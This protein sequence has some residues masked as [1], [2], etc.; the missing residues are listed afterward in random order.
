MTMKT[1][2]E[3]IGE[4]SALEQL[5]EECAE[6]AQASL[7]LARKIRSENPTPKSKDQCVADILEEIAD[8]QEAIHVMEGSSWYDGKKIDDLITTKDARWHQRLKD[9]E[10]NEPY[11]KHV[12]MKSPYSNK[13]TS[14]NL[15]SNCNHAQKT[16]SPYCGGCGK[17]LRRIING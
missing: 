5:A 1:I 17:R 8:V 13:Y 11:W 9:A 16:T 14:I 6:L 15:C 2:I 4:A 7:K 10:K 3:A 12:S